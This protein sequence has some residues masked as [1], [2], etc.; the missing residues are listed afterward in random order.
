MKLA[1]KLSI[2]L[3]FLVAV[4]IAALLYIWSSLDVLVASAIEKYGS[5]VTGTSV[6]V[7]GVQLEL[8][9]GKG[10]ISGITVG[11]PSGFSQPNAFSLG[12]ISTRVDVNT[13]TA[14]P[15]VIDEITIK[16]PEIFY[17]IN[18]KGVSNFDELKKNI[19]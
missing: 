4:L 7:A 19:A 17:E 8:T 5:Q 15:V 16:A 14:N 9:Q 6:G 3:V 1:G 12:N 11:N 2:I 13:V 10:S 18:K